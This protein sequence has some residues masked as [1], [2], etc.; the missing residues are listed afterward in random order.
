MSKHVHGK[1]SDK[2]HAES[3]DAGGKIQDGAGGQ[4][5]D[6]QPAAEPSGVDQPADASAGG[7]SVEA[8]D[9]DAFVEARIQREVTQVREELGAKIASA[10]AELSNLK[11]QYLRKAAEFENFRKRMSKDKQDAIDFANQ[12]LLLDLIQVIDDFERAIKSSETS[13]DFDTLHAGI[14]LIEKRLV[15]QLENKWGL[16]RFESVGAPFDPNRHEAIMMEKSKDVAE[17]VVG[18]DF[19][20]GYTLKE[21]VVRSAKVKVIMPEDEG[22]SASTQ[23]QGGGNA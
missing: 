7:N 2:V 10:E 5:A 17:A 11:D 6:G 13:R 14:N 15:S 9:Q 4:P 22:S 20:H 23:E 3:M 18:E 21:R 12:S 1:A 8:K 16:V 19:V